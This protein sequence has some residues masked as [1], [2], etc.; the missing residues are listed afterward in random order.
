[1]LLEHF[2][3]RFSLKGPSASFVGNGFFSLQFLQRHEMTELS[4]GSQKRCLFTQLLMD[5]MELLSISTHSRF[6]ELPGR[7][8][9]FTCFWDMETLKSHLFST[10]EPNQLA[11]SVL[12][13]RYGLRVVG[14][15]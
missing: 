7:C 14:V 4:I 5:C 3:E 2:G 11:I 12:L 13:F 10:W 1:M 8:F 15:S 6:W 9:P